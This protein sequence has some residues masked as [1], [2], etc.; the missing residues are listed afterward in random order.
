MFWDKLFGNKRDAVNTRPYAE[1]RDTIKTG[2]LVFVC[3][4]K[5]LFSWLITAVTRSSYSH[6]GIACWLYDNET[7]SPMLFIVEAA[8]SGRRLVSMSHYGYKRPMA[9]VKSPIVWEAYR[10]D[11]M[12]NTGNIAYGYFDL[13]AIGLKELF[14][15]KSK[16]FDGEVC[17]EMVATVLNCNGFYIDEMVS[18]GKLFD[19]LIARGCML[20]AITTPN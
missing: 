11:L 17:S 6:V 1:V 19:L 13:F 7:Q 8:P 18:P 5:S 16:D 15:I 10:R 2:D 14:G 4:A 20:K 12:D 3:G 9:I